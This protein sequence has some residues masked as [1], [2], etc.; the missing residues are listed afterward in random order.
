[1]STRIVKFGGIRSCF[2]IGQISKQGN[3]MLHRRFLVKLCVGATL[4]LVIAGCATGRNAQPFCTEVP[5]GISAATHDEMWNV[6]K[7][8][9]LEFGYEV[10]NEDRELDS[11]LCTLG[12]PVGGYT[13]L[14]A[15]E[16]QQF[17]VTSRGTGT[18]V[19]LLGSVVNSAKSRRRDMISALSEIAGL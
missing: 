17:C 3:I 5:G 15:F 4:P 1:M 14:V 19:P 12:S 18:R 16:P 11:I 9:C 8:K 10:A 6:A 2:Q 13:L 7:R